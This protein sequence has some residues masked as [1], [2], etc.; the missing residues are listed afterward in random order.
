MC[1]RV[2][3]EGQ[4]GSCLPGTPDLTFPESFG[5]ISCPPPPVSLPEEA[6]FVNGR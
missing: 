1:D 2:A 6:D 5:F 3:G 4:T